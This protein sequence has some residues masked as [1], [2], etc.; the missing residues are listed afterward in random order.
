MLYVVQAS[1][2]REPWRKARN[3]RFLQEKYFDMRQ[4]PTSAKK[5]LKSTATTPVIGRVLAASPNTSYE[6]TCLKQVRLWAMRPLSQAGV[7][8]FPYMIDERPKLER[9]VPSAGIE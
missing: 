8:P 5:S 6:H 7:A 2:L 3:K 9:Q 4:D 1:W